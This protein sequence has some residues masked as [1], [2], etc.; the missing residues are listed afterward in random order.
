VSL[1]KAA[2]R[3]LIVYGYQPSGHA[4]AAF[5][6]EEAFRARGFLVDLV[7]VAGDHHPAAALAVARGYHSLLGAF[8]SVWGGLYASD[9]ARKVLSAVRRSYLRLGGGRRLTEGV[10]RRAPDVVVCPQASVAAVFAAARKAGHLDVP[11]VGVMT[12]YGVHPFWADPAA[13]LVVVPTQ[14]A[15][16]RLRAVGV[17][18]DRS[19]IIGIPIH[20][21]FAV[22][23]DRVKARVDL[24]LPS[25]APVV[26]VS[27]G[28]KGFG[29]VDRTAAAVLQACPRA[30][31]LVLCGAN[32]GLRR[33]LSARRE[34]GAR[35]RVFGPQPPAFVAT[36]L[37]SADLHVGKPGGLTAAESLAVGVP[38]VLSRPLP[39][40]E[41]G[42][43]RHLLRVGAAVE[44][45]SPVESARAASK[46]LGERARL[47]AMRASAAS[48]GRP[49]AARLVVDA[50]AGLTHAARTARIS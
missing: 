30:S 8:P 18:P 21:A 12:D 9:G 4:A 17:P 50:V 6:L 34:S 28:S 7:E 1:S 39:G 19:K 42:N 33:A 45:G 13:D 27:G 32:D 48:A 3:V 23:Q 26:L 5:S 2:A 41:E 36:L 16:D 11:V 43:A 47:A 22:P 44:G 14:E 31:V 10:A 35:L 37:A 15:A 29:A 49:D 38:M 20:P 40:Q 24:G 25:A 46:L